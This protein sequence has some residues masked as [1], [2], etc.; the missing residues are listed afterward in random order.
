MYEVVEIA[1]NQE[2]QGFEEEVLS[3]GVAEGKL[4]ANIFLA[5]SMIV[6]VCIIGYAGIY[7]AFND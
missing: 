1:P 2:L 3:S 4:D 6:S 5:G 7:Y